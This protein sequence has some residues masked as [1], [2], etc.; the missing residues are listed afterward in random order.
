MLFRSLASCFVFTLQAQEVLPNIVLKATPDGSKTL[1]LSLK[2]LSGAMDVAIDWG[3][4]V[5]QNIA[6]VPAFIIPA[7]HD[8]TGVPKGSGTIKVY[9]A[10]IAFFSC[11]FTKDGVKLTEVN[12]TRAPELLDLDISSHGLSSIDLSKNTKLTRFTSDN[13]AFETINLTANT[14]LLRISMLNNKLKNLDLSKNTK[15][16]Y[17]HFGTNG[18]TELDLKANKDL[19]DVNLLKNELIS[20]DLSENKELKFLNVASNRFKS[21]EITK[22]GRASCRERV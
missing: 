21:L 20:L 15:L 13:N 16:I 11:S 17:I 4:G 9:G 12:V 14:E 18:L 22:I 19:T 8:E 10:D 3:D 6:G 2:T 5:K 7:A 1:T